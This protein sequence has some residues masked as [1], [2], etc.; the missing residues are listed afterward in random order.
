MT[1]PKRRARSLRVLDEGFEVRLCIVMLLLGCDQE[2]VAAERGKRVLN[3]TAKLME[4]AKNKIEK[5]QG[6]VRPTQAPPAQA[7]GPAQASS[8]AP[9]RVVV[10]TSD[11]DWGLQCRFE[12]PPFPKALTRY[13][14]LANGRPFARVHHGDSSLPAGYGRGSLLEPSLLRP[15]E[16]PEALGLVTRFSCRVTFSSGVLKSLL[17]GKGPKNIVV[18]SG[19]VVFPQLKTWREGPL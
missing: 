6:A 4:A 18:T 11:D 7:A 3:E 12:S 14:W 19:S 1:E 5:V 17:Q 10:V 9:T 13:Q 15:R 2:P 8:A 16:V